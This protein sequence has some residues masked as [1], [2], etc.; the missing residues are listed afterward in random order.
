MNAE[1]AESLEKNENNNIKL[2]KKQ[3]QKSLDVK[4]LKGNEDNK[5]IDE[6]LNA[7]RNKSRIEKFN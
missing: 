4:F 5:I 2:N 1:S 6:N 7:I 3:F